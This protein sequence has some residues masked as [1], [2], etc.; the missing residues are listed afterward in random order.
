MAAAA[1]TVGNLKKLLPAEGKVP[2]WRVWRPWRRPD[3]VHGV[4]VCARTAETI[5]T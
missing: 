4:R 5:S 3:L 1:L 2:G